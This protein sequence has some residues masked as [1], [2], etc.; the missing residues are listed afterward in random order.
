MEKLRLRK[1]KCICPGSHGWQLISLEL[2]YEWYPSEVRA[3]LLRCS[4]ALESKAAWEAGPDAAGWGWLAGRLTGTVTSAGLCSATFQG[5]GTPP[6]V[7]PWWPWKAVDPHFFLRD[8][9]AE[10]FQPHCGQLTYYLNVLFLFL[11]L[12]AGHSSA[13]MAA[14]RVRFLKNPFNLSCKL[15]QFWEWK[16]NLLIIM[17]GLSWAPKAM[18][19]LPILDQRMELPWK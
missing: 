17:P 19:T 13:L 10:S 14:F 3:P 4:R 7:A 15:G 8:S 1:V 11:W 9:P 6:S 18:V 2:E 5:R 16:G 12:S